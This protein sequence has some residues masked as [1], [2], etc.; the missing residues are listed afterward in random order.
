MQRFTMRLLSQVNFTKGKVYT[1]RNGK[2]FLKYKV[3]LQKHKLY[4]S[5]FAFSF[6]NIEVVK[7]EK[8]E[9]ELKIDNLTVAEILRVY[10]NNNGVEF[11]A[12][13]REHPSKPLLFRI[14]SSGKT[15][16]KAVS[17][18]VDAIKKDC[19]KVLGA[20]KKK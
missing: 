3:C 10:L 17:E 14:E 4:K 15:V 5:I 12:W 13:K 8:N 11:A 16:K 1:M 19:D 20:I 2:L 18:A 6:M 7:Q 9:V